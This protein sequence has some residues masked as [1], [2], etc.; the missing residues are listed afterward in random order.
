MIDALIPYIKAFV[1]GGLFCLIG[2]IL[3][4]KT[5]NALIL[6]SSFF[7]HKISFKL[8]AQ[9]LIFIFFYPYGFGFAV[10]F[11]DNTDFAVFG[12][13]LIIEKVSY[14]MT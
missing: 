3:I 8:K 11:E 7:I 1:V 12:I 14:F 6:A 2:Q 4:D 13:K 5:K 9:V 10:S